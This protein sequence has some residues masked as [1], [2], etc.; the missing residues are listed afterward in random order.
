LKQGNDGMPVA[1]IC[2][3]AGISFNWKK[4]Y[5]GLLP[6]EMRRL[7]QLEDDAKFARW[8]PI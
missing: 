2:R 7:K 6:T 5:E 1:D 3:K 8:S 4:K